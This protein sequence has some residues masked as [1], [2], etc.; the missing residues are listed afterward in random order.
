M[1]LRDAV[2]GLVVMAVIG[3]GC[4]PV[5]SVSLVKASEPRIAFEELHRDPERY[6][7]KTVVF[8]GTIIEV[9]HGD[10]GTVV[11]I[12]QRPLGWGLKPQ[13]NDESG[14]RFLVRF[15]RVLNE[16]GWER[17]RRITLAGKVVGRETRPLD[18]TTYTYP[19]IRVE[20]YYLWPGPPRKPP[21]ITIGF[22]VSGTL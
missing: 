5:I 22:G 18:Q 6:L 15:G 7:G 3:P 14:G 21:D 2:W 4:A 1:R 19:V 20:D 9:E 17:H 16:A 12:L 13:I 10:S 8:G 11:E